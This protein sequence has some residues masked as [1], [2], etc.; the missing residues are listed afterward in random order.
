MQ[1]GI[2]KY[3]NPL[4]GWSYGADSPPGGVG[5]VE[6]LHMWRFATATIDFDTDGGD[7][8][9]RAVRQRQLGR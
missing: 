5:G 3:E 2:C 6:N 7:H 9:H 1:C 4:R 8:L